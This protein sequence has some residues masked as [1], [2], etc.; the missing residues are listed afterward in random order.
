MLQVSVVAAAC[1]IEEPVVGADTD[2]PYA[3]VGAGESLA[4]AMTWQA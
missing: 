3:R 4:A 2:F 1:V